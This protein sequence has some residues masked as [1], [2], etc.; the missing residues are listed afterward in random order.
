MV[1]MVIIL[2]NIMLIGAVVSCI[3]VF[4]ITYAI[5]KLAEHKNKKDN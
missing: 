5:D 2:R 4:G 3:G 1:E